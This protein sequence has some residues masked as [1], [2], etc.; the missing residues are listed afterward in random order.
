M[1]TMGAGS[2]ASRALMRMQ[3]FRPYLHWAIPGRG[4]LSYIVRSSWMTVLSRLKDLMVR[5][6][7]FHYGM[8]RLKR[9]VDVVIGYS[10]HLLNLYFLLDGIIELL[11]LLLFVTLLLVLPN[12]VGI[13]LV[14]GLSIDGQICMRSDR[15]VP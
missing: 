1:I 13:S 9:V 2:T 11:G 6:F 7:W 4:P 14:H 8:H 12:E 10:S 3:S 15:P 5:S